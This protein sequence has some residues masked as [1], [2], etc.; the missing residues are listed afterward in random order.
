[1]NQPV[2]LAAGGVLLLILGVALGYLVAAIRHSKMQARTDAVKAE[3]DAYRE[4]VTGHFRE[5]AVQFQALGEQYRSLYRHMADGAQALCETP[6]TADAI[7]FS[8]FPELTQEG[9]AGAVTQ[10]DEPA[11]TPSQPADADVRPRDYAESDD[12][13]GAAEPVLATATKEAAEPAAELPS[14]PETAPKRTSAISA[15]VAAADDA[16]PPGDRTVH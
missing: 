9:E 11:P 15:P 6:A 10:P 8:P 14:G 13:P 2:L 12:G 16:A 5:T 7:G 4:N 1:M 3:Y